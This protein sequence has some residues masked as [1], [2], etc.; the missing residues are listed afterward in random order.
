MK[1]NLLN[2]PFKILCNQNKELL[3][4]HHLWLPKAIHFL[5]FFSFLWKKYWEFQMYFGGGNRWPVW[6]RCLG[7][8]TCLVMVL[9]KKRCPK[10]VCHNGLMLCQALKILERQKGCLLDGLGK[11]SYVKTSLWCPNVLPWYRCFK[12]LLTWHWTTITH[13]AYSNNLQLTQWYYQQHHITHS[14]TDIP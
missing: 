12:A 9:W 3:I 14:K 1:T 11:F 5:P 8:K 2:N 6:R 13:S 10:S 4:T 7:T